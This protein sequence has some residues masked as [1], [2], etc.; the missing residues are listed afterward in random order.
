MGETVPNS[1]RA[2]TLSA[3][4]SGATSAQ[5]EWIRNGEVVSTSRLIEGRPATLDL[6]VEAGNWFSVI[7]HDQNGPILFSNAIYVAK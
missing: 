7:V 4:V 3:A 1:V 2:L 5:V 6:A